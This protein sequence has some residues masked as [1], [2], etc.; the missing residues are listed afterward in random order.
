[1]L[2]KRKSP[3]LVVAEFLWELRYD[4]QSRTFWYCKGSKRVKNPIIEDNKNDWKDLSRQITPGDA[5]PHNSWDCKYYVITP[6]CSHRRYA[7]RF[8]IIITFHRVNGSLTLRKTRQHPWKDHPPLLQSISPPLQISLCAVNSFAIAVAII[9]L[10]R[11]QFRQRGCETPCAV[12]NFAIAVAITTLH[13]EQF[14]YRGCETLCAV[15][16]FAIAVAIATLRSEQFH[17][18]GC[19]TLCAVSNFAIAVAIATLRSEQFHDRGCEAFCAC[20]ISVLFIGKYKNALLT[21]R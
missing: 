10:R 7:M 1:M 9:T 13:S 2:R 5:S 8:M 12:N 18:R 14:R 11:E 19:E 15:S 6:I 3:W 4:F 16:N 21:T 20:R 17:Y